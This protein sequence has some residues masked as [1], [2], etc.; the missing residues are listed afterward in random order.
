MSRVLAYI[1]TTGLLYPRDSETSRP[2]RKKIDKGVGNGLLL[3]AGTGEKVYNV[4]LGHHILAGKNIFPG[5]PGQGG[6][7]GKQPGRVDRILQVL[8]GLPL[9]VLNS[10]LFIFQHCVLD[11]AFQPDGCK[12]GEQQRDQA[13]QEIGCQHTAV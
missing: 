13:G 10:R 12:E 11:D 3:L 9:D 6:V 8:V 4:P 2:L 7:S 1:S 5:Q